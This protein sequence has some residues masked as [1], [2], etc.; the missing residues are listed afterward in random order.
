MRAS[1]FH[2]S[3]LRCGR[4][5]HV[6]ERCQVAVS[7][8]WLPPRDPAAAHEQQDELPAEQADGRPGPTACAWGSSKAAQQGRGTS[9]HQ[10][11]P[12]VDRHGPDFRRAA[13]APGERDTSHRPV[14][15]GKNA[16]QPCI[17]SYGIVFS[18][19][20]SETGL[21]G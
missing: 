18:A 16:T 14:C 11:V 12:S 13:A 9:S 8:A 2:L 4:L 21:Q 19:P 3:R 1:G 15:A 7:I 10:G 17:G 5:V 20:R 6:P